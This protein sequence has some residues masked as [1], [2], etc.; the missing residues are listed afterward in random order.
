[1]AKYSIKKIASEI[2]N[3]GNGTVGGLLALQGK[4]K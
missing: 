4:N 3:G 1:M 2:L